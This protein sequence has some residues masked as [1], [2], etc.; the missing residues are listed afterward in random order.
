MPSSAVCC[1]PG[2]LVPLVCSFLLFL[3]PMFLSLA[4]VFL[5]QF[6]LVNY[7]FSVCILHVSLFSYFV[8][9][10]LLKMGPSTSTLCLYLTT[11]PWWVL[12]FDF[13]LF[14][15]KHPG[16]SWT[17]ADLG[18]NLDPWHLGQ[19]LFYY[20]YLTKKSQYVYFN[21]LTDAADMDI[22]TNWLH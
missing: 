22:A 15:S 18:T 3:S 6:Q 17:L 19:N 7:P 12:L 11:Q 9:K 16:I 8:L 14:F 13:F 10:T 20:M 4:Y 21:W 2:L 1:N 5:E